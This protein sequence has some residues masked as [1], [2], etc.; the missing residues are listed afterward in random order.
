MPVGEDVFT[1]SASDS[2][3]TNPNNQ[4]TYAFVPGDGTLVSSA[5]LL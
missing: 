4:I 5:E 2:D 1:V 3:N